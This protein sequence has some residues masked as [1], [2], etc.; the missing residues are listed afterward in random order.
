MS[1]LFRKKKNKNKTKKRKRK[2]KKKK[3]NLKELIPRFFWFWT[4]VEER[5]HHDAKGF[6]RKSIQKISK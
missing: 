3:T 5:L 1:L 6:S 4:L 2:K